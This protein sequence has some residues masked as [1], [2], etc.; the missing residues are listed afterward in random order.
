MSRGPLRSWPLK[1]NPYG[2]PPRHGAADAERSV[3]SQHSRRRTKQ[4]AGDPVSIERGVRQ[5]LA[6]KVTGHLVGLWL[7][8]PEHLRLGTWDLVRNWTG[9]PAEC[10]EPRLALQLVHQAALCSA[11]VRPDRTIATRGGFELVNGL[12]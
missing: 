1:K 12:P 9:Q 5:M 8:V 2:G 11:G 10:L 4:V 7:L 3:E 6:D